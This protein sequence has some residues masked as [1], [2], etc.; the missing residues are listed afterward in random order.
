MG[1]ERSEEEDDIDTKRVETN[2][3]MVNRKRNLRKLFGQDLNSKKT[4]KKRNF[5]SH[6]GKGKNS[7]DFQDKKEYNLN[8]HNIDK[9][10][11]YV[12]PVSFLFL[13]IFYFTYSC[14]LHQAI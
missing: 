11:R 1:L 3:N 9:A 10:S 8:V 14:L 13:N 12:F 7:E 5:R 4:G 2:S 6:Y